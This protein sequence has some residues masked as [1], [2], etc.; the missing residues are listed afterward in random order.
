MATERITATYWMETAHEPL[1]VA[2]TIAGEQSSG[3]FVRVPGETEELRARFGA[4]VESL[5]LL[6]ESD[7]PS[8]PYSRYPNTGTTA[9]YRSA[10]LVL[11]WPL[12]N[13]GPSLPGLLATVAGNL[14][15]LA[16]LSGL[17][18]LDLDLPPSFARAYPGPRCGV[19][20]TRRLSGVYGRPLI[21]TIVKP[22]V[23]LTPEQTAE[24]VRNLV[25]A[26]IDFIKDDELM[27]DP[28][29][30]PFEQ[31]V[32]LVMAVIEALAQKNGRKAMY[33]FNLTGDIDEMARRAEAVERAGGTCLMASVNSVGL[34]G[35]AWLRARTGLPIHAHRNGW[36][37]LTRCA[38]L[39]FDFLAWHKL[40]RLAGADHIHVNG[41]RNK[42]WEP[43]ES[44]IASARAC[45]TPMLGG[46]QAMPVFSSGQWAAQAPDTYH[47]LGSTDLLYLCGG[48]MMAHP[49]GPAAG[50]RSIQQAWEAAIADVPLARYAETH[51]ELREALERF[52]R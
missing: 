47:A 22:S 13:M 31:R 27:A 38:S 46:Y 24:L 35:M 8:L 1:R 33:A 45:L 29:H 25:E 15:E 30:S 17:R 3:T 44:V 42:F 34:P 4:R 6:G 23:G 19:A 48:G 52:Q 28:P 18:L 14:F 11:S 51:S 41:I 50:L 16:E 43:D 10:R 36:G 20:G 40:W 26:G 5:T 7:L 37:Y 12:E 21:G 32:E 2:E 9:V 39:G 49:S